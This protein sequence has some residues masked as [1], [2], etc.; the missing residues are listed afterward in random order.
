ME[1]SDVG[2]S[3][4]DGAGSVTEHVQ[5][6]PD[7]RQPEAL[8]ARDVLDNDEARPDL[9]DDVR[10]VPPE[11]RLLP[12]DASL[13]SCARDVLTGEASA[14]EVHMGIV[15]RSRDI[16]EPR[17]GGPVLREHAAAEGI[18]LAVP[19]DRTEACALEAELEPADARE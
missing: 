8:A 2:G 1:G 10:V 14:D 3:K 19:E 4:C 16:L 13:G 7:V 9:P 6:V 5:L 12:S 18:D 15:S 11:R 17:D